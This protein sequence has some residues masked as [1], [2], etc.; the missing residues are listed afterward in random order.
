MDRLLL[1]ARL[2]AAGVDLSGRLSEFFLVDFVP[3][4]SRADDVVVMAM[5]M[6]PFLPN[7]VDV[8]RWRRHRFSPGDTGWGSGRARCAGTLGWGNAPSISTIQAG[9][10]RRGWREQRQPPPD[11]GADDEVADPSSASSACGNGRGTRRRSQAHNESFCCDWVRA[12]SRSNARGRLGGCWRRWG[13]FGFGILAAS[14]AEA[15]GEG[16][17]R[18]QRPGNSGGRA[19]I[20]ALQIEPQ[21]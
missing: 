8:T 10:L 13:C 18:Q 2:A 5:N 7:C 3:L 16:R 1:A 9:S 4:L 21:F 17:D 14:A 20:A 6:C 11:A 19:A 12:L 15:A